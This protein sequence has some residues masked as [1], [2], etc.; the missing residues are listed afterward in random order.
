[1][2]TMKKA[3]WPTLGWVGTLGLWS[4]GCVSPAVDADQDG[5]SAEVDCNDADASIFPGA[6]DIP[7]D[8]VDQDCSGKDLVDAD[9]DGY[10]DTQDCNDAD[11][12]INPGA[13]D[14][15]IDAV[16]A[17]CSGSDAKLTVVLSN[18]RSLG[19]YAPAYAISGVAVGDTSGKEIVYASDPNRCVIW[20]L[21]P[22]GSVE[23]A[24]GALDSCGDSGDGGP[25]TRAQIGTTYDI[26]AVAHGTG[27][28]LY[29]MDSGNNRL[30]RVMADGKIQTVAGNGD[31]DYYGDGGIATDAALYYPYYFGVVTLQNGNDVIYLAES[32]SI[33]R[34]GP[35]GRINTVAGSRDYYAD[36]MSEGS[37][38]LSVYM[39]T[40]QELNPFISSE[41]ES[42]YF[43]SYDRYQI[44][45]MAPDQK[46]Y[47]TVG[48]GSGGYSGEG[49]LALESSLYSPLGMAVD[50]PLKPTR[51]YFV[52]GSNYRVRVV[53]PDGRV[54][55][56]AG[57]GTNRQLEP[58][59][60]TDTS[61]GYA[62]MLAHHGKGELYFTFYNND[63]TSGVAKLTPD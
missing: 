20:R 11:A 21:N 16:D 29:L 63:G 36:P 50:N 53:N 33:R 35:D 3:L 42:V 30:R 62:S 25:A 34:V 40:I 32:G 58:G 51:L 44:W 23:V 17:N 45:R 59:N 6:T 1:M 61:I 52:D 9:S 7:Y 46:L 4:A 2:Q 49:E 19:F 13:S 55:T 43:I 5:A 60:A 24:V 41:G 27:H 22:D 37:D 54:Y 8:G 39:G 38:G 47:A 57:D 31:Y 10:D 28:Y 15:V 26:Q 18:S 12:Q 48:T 14:A 56:V